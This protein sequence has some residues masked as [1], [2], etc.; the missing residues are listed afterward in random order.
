MRIVY[1]WETAAVLGKDAQLDCSV[2]ECLCFHPALDRIKDS[3]FV[4]G[5]ENQAAL[6]ARGNGLYL[7]EKQNP[8]VF[9]CLRW[10]TWHKVREIPHSFTSW[11]WQPQF[12]HAANAH[13]FPGWILRSGV[14]AHS[15]FSRNWEVLAVRE[16]LSES[17]SWHI[18]Q[19]SRRKKEWKSQDITSYTR[20]CT[21][22]SDILV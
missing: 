4:V 1:S 6:P 15:R 2:W 18:A 20:S 17:F 13:S 8:K 5:S 16:P 11:C 12:R 19:E 10:R 14:G 9:I 3:F 21:H 7:G 22:G